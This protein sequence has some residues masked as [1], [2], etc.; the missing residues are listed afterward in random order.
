[1]LIQFDKYEEELV[2][3]WGIYP[4]GDHLEKVMVDAGFV[5]I[6]VKKIQIDVGNWRG[7]GGNLRCNPI[8]LT[9]TR[10]LGARR[11][12][13]AV[14]TGAFGALINHMKSAYPDQEERD[15]F[16][17]RVQADLEN[18]EYKLYTISYLTL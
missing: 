8:T 1:L 2:N 11:A 4:K 13:L 5:D 12:A 10:I 16:T 17:K 18:P 3:I 7:G 15:K 6:K 14:F 9:G